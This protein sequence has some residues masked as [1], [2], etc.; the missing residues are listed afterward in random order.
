MRRELEVD[1]ESGAD[2][3]NRLKSGS[4][5]SGCRKMPHYVLLNGMQLDANWCSFNRH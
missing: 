2:L 1:R 4:L 5:D 3:I